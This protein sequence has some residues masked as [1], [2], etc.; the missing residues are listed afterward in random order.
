MAYPPRSRRTKRR[1]R[2]TF[3]GTAA[4]ICI[5]A[6]AV[7]MLG[8]ERFEGRSAPLAGTPVTLRVERGVT[9][10][11]VASVRAGVL[12][13]ENYS[14]RLLGHAVRDTVDA[15]VSG[16]SGCR[17]LS[18]TDGI[19]VGEAERGR[20]C[21]DTRSLRWQWLVLKDRTAAAVIAAHEYAHV[22]QADLGCLPSS[23]TQQPRWLVE[24]MATE[25]AWRALVVA[26]QATWDQASASIE[27]SGAF[28]PRLKQ[29]RHYEATGGGDPEYA[30]W[31]GAFAAMPGGPAR[32]VRW[33]RLTGA[34]MPWRVAFRRVFGLSSAQFYERFERARLD[35]MLTKRLVL[36]RE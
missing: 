20:L 14:R 15:R 5:V 19:P 35:A 27:E 17:L 8:G 21:I 23:D 29:L 28:D 13:A 6:A 2:A 10:Q 9:A 36:T 30:L 12:A 34:G 1:R 22:V 31:H 18:H 24:G 16:A 7:S 3:A 11:D 33:C 4:F 32:L 25:V 26:R